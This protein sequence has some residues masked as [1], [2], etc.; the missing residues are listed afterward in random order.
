MKQPFHSKK[1]TLWFYHF[2]FFFH[3]ISDRNVFI[4]SVASCSLYTYTSNWTTSDFFPT[5]LTMFWYTTPPFG[6]EGI[7]TSLDLIW[8]R[9]HFDFFWEWRITS[10]ATKYTH[11][12][13]HTHKKKKYTK[14]CITSPNWVCFVWYLKTTKNTSALYN[15]RKKK[16][17][18]THI[19]KR[20]YIWLFCHF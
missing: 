10:K 11:T 18:H 5:R 17:V 12:H 1:E 7:V 6:R 3:N 14:L 19:L 15:V 13:T 4:F 20:Y 8:Q 2:Y 16:N 9:H